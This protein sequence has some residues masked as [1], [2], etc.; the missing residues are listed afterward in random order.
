MLQLT[1]E[2]QSI[3]SHDYGPALVFAV[4]GSGKTTAM[5]HRIER[6]VREKVFPAHKILATSFSKAA[7]NDIKHLLRNWSHCER[8]RTSTLHALGFQVVRQACSRGMLGLSDAAL[9]SITNRA[10]S[11]RRAREPEVE[12]EELGAV[13]EGHGREHEDALAVEAHR[14][15]LSEHRHRPSRAAPSIV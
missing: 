14:F 7:V 1:D 3:V 6:L 10:L 8:V 2:Q 5:V 9:L 15:R 11:C 13:L 12:E 4:A